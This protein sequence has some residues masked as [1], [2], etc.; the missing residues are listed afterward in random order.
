MHYFM[1]ILVLCAGAIVLVSTV[2]L[3]IGYLVLRTIAT[4]A[5]FLAAIA[6]EDG[7]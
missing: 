4:G 6:R 1:M 7:A 5:A 2:L 3:G